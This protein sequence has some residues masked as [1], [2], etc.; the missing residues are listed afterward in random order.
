MTVR[1][2]FAGQKIQ[3]RQANTMQKGPKKEGKVT[4]VRERRSRMVP[5]G[6]GREKEGPAP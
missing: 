3:R 4:K 2:A 1:Q 5:L 6:K